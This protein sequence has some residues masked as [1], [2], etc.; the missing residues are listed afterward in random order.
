M[1]AKASAEEPE[2]EPKDDKKPKKKSAPTPEQI[3]LEQIRKSR[4]VSD[5][6]VRL[7]DQ[8]IAIKNVISTGLPDLDRILTPML[9]ESSGI[10]GIPRGFVAEFFGPFAGGKSSLC[11]KLAAGVTKGGGYVLWFDAEGSYVPEWAARHGVDNGKVIIVDSGQSGEFYLEQ[12]ES[13][14]TKG[15]VDLI[16]VDSVTA[17]VPK[18]VL[19]TNLEKEAR[20]GAGAKM[21]TRALPRIV[22]AA[23][24]GNVAVVFVNQIRQKIGVMYGCFHGE[25]PVTFVDGTTHF[26]KDVVKNK[27]TGPIYAFDPETS[28]IHEAKITNW[29]NNGKLDEDSEWITVCSDSS[30]VANGLVSFTCTKNHKVLSQGKWIEAQELKVGSKLTSFYDSRLSNDLLREMIFGTLLGDGTLRLR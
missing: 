12:V 16:V 15:Q 27:L 19:E 11:M 8:H 5:D 17:M 6:T 30:G 26:I 9:W 24:K 28:R 29:F 25:T 13:A 10:G 20:I 22:T 14:A 2:E 23:K 1:K 7:A 3:R 21:M 4:G 18:E